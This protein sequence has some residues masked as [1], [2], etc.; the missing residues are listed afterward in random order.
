[1]YEQN[2]EFFLTHTSK[3]GTTTGIMFVV[4][5]IL[6][7]SSLYCEGTLFVLLEQCIKQVYSIGSFLWF[8][9]RLVFH[10]AKGFKLGERVKKVCYGTSPYTL[11]EPD[12]IMYTAWFAVL[13]FGNLS[14]VT[15][16]FPVQWHSSQEKKKTFAMLNQDIKKGVPFYVSTTQQSSV[17]MARNLKSCSS[18][19]FKEVSQRFLRAF[20]FSANNCRLVIVGSLLFLESRFNGI[21]RSP[22]TSSHLLI[23][24]I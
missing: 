5:A 22:I 16:F 3:Q 24:N 19:S 10:G 20:C 23:Q 1:M 14:S 21:C 17:H 13:F 2:L 9:I 18:N 15:T 12:I 8:V 4:C 7:R 6:Q 11:L